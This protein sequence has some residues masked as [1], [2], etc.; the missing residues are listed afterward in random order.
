MF[1]LDDFK[2]IE[3]S[4]RKSNEVL[5]RELKAENKKLRELLEFALGGLRSAPHSWGLDI[6]HVRKI[7][8]ELK[9]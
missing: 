8:K 9:K 7:E 1:N 4:T 3:N 2:G 5:I 6:T